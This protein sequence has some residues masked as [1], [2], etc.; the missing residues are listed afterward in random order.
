MS[1]IH[2]VVKKLTGLQGT[3]LRLVVCIETGNCM[4]CNKTIIQEEGF[5]FHVGVIRYETNGHE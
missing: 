5:Y 4:G 3:W 2:V 1:T